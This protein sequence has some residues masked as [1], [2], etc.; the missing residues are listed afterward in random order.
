MN[1]RGGVGKHDVTTTITWLH[2]TWRTEWRQNS[3]GGNKPLRT[4]TI[5]GGVVRRLEKVIYNWLPGWYDVINRNSSRGQKSRRRDRTFAVYLFNTETYIRLKLFIYFIQ[6]KFSL[7]L[8]HKCTI[9]V[10]LYN[11]RAEIWL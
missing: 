4:Q 8:I 2:Q 9:D 1:V 5:L 7:L 6:S 11:L 10:W 3:G